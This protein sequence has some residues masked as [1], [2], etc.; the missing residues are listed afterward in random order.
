MPIFRLIQSQQPEHGHPWT[1]TGNFMWVVPLDG[2]VQSVQGKKIE[3][4][5]LRVNRA[6]SCSRDHL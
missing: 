1:V 3:R 6:Q 2:S 5:F 4:G